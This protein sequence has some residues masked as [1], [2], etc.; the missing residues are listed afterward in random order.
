MFSKQQKATGSGTHTSSTKRTPQ[1]V[2]AGENRF[3]FRKRLFRNPREIP[4]DPVQVNLLYAQAVYS[5]VRVSCSWRIL[6]SFLSK[7]ILPTDFMYIICCSLTVFCSFLLFFP[8]FII[9]NPF[10]ELNR[11]G[12][13][14]CYNYFHSATFPSPSLSSY[15]L[16]LGA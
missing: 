4:S 16:H 9:I 1:T 12:I 2:N 7:C 11:I 8:P 14:F 6:C 10:P 3:V 15:V 5:V 13:L